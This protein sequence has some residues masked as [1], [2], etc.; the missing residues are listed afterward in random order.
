V[1]RFSA[2]LGFLW[3]ELPLL[4]RIAAAAR[5]GFKAVELHWPYDVPAEAVRAACARG[6]VSLLAVNTSIGDAAKG[7]F[8]LGALPGRERDFQ[9]AVDQS[10][11]YCVAAGA[12]AIHAMAGVV[13]PEAREEARRVLERNLSDAAE[14][15]A[16]VGLTLL[17][18][19]INPRDK[20][21]YFYATPE[22][23]SAVIEAVAR[24]NVK[25]L[26][27]VYH[28]AIA[29]GDVIMRLRRYFGAIGHVQIAAVPSRAEPD[30][31]EMA[32]AAVFAELDRLGYEGWIGC[33]Y[34][35]RAGTEA[36]L[37]WTKAL[38]VSL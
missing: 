17:L 34:R 20:P 26:F 19:P 5:V 37:K 10:I 23:V 9:T 3:P 16:A 2:N 27:D 30:E 35:P 1:G 22:E 12:A 25:M 7:E 11:A 4:D 18:E 32:Y 33:E 21:G 14:R 31:G 15:A 6:Q 28:A 36:G 24:P 13:S 8:G 38:G 29:G